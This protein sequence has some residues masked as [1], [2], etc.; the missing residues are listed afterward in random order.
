MPQGNQNRYF[1]VC[2]GFCAV[3]YY[4]QIWQDMTSWKIWIYCVKLIEACSRYYCK[5]LLVGGGI[6]IF[7]YFLPHRLVFCSETVKVVLWGCLHL[8]K[9]RCCMCLASQ[10]NCHGML[11]FEVQC[12][13][14]LTC[15]LCSSHKEQSGTKYILTLSV[16]N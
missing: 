8:H 15:D 6:I 7:K 2:R 11:M 16:P 5:H 12:W 3:S 1:V 9:L 13:Y 14:A 10:N 4:S